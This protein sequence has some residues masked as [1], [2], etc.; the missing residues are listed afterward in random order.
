MENNYVVYKHLKPDGE[1]FY[2]GMGKPYRP[3][4]KHGR[5]SSWNNTVKKHGYT[6]EI[7][8]KNLSLEEAIELEISLIKAYGRKDLGLGTLVNLT[9][10]GDRRS[11]TEEQKK[12]LSISNKGVKHIFKSE[13]SLEIN[14]KNRFK[15]GCKVNNKKVIN[16][17]TGE[18]YESAKE[19]H[20]LTQSKYHVN[21]FR[22]M[23]AGNKINKTKFKY[24]E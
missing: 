21:H 3:R 17:K 12:Q 9:D 5:S 15:P 8:F 18:I 22:D 13:E 19:C 10:G 6:V 7:L 24:Y 20:L 23:I 1:V 4:Y 16:T 14:K 2:I 11:Y